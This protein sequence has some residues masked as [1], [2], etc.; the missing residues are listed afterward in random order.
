MQGLASACLVWGAR[1]HET[2]IDMCRRR[3]AGLLGKHVHELCSVA[4][5]SQCAATL[6]HPDADTLRFT[7]G[8]VS[9][10]LLV[11]CIGAA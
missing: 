9:H 5:L 11:T 8:L 1:E 2:A 3:S 6:L 7:W 4:T 10:C